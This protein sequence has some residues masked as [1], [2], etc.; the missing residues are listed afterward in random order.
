MNPFDFYGFD[1]AWQKDC[2]FFVELSL[3]TDFEQTS[4][5]VIMATIDIQVS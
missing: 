4:R 5:M 3:K 2:Q 1:Y